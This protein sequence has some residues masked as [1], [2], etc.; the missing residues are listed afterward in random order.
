MRPSQNVRRSWPVLLSLAIL[1]SSACAPRSEYFGKVEPPPGQVFRFNNAAEPEYLDPG[2]MVGQ[3]EGR[4]A[5]L[6]FEGLT[7]IDSVTHLP[8]PGIAESWETSPDGK[9]Y[10]FH[11]RKDAVWS[12]GMPVTARDFVFAWTRVL[13]PKLASRYANLIYFI[14][15]GQEFN[16]GRLQD[17]SQLGLK[18]I[19]DHTLQV[20]LRKPVPF[21][22]TLTAFFSYLPV[23][24]H[25]VE[26][27]AE[28]WSNP[29]H[30]VGN[31][32]F[33]LAEHQ[34]NAKFEF[35]KN[36]RYWNA[37]EVRLER[38]IAYSIDDIHTSANMYEAGILDWVP[39]GSFPSSYVPYMRTRYHDLDSSV[40]LAS[41]YYEFNVTRRPL[42]N[43]LVRRA[44]SMAVDRRALTDDLL[45]GGQIPTAHFVPKGMP[46]YESP[47]GPEYNP[48]EARRL[49]AEAGY[50]NG[51]GFPSIDILFNTLDDHKRI[52]EA[53]QQMW[54]KNLN[55]SVKVRNEEWASYLKSRRNLQYDVVRAGWIGDYPDPSTFTDLL[56]SNNGNND[57]GWKNPAY[58]RLI[59]SAR[60][61]PDPFKR[62]EILRKSEAMALDEMPI[63]PL[64]TYASN[65][66]IKPYV[67]GIGG[68]PTDQHLLNKVWID[69]EWTKHRASAE[70]KRD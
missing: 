8:V 52:A 7:T 28:H 33:L 4:I 31:G 43:R 54:S 65:Q 19:D 39:S 70:E 11:L 26:Q 21:F 61:E 64:Y 67:R 34:T 6:V 63:L 55:I 51:Q 10:T 37:R 44:L 5:E 14:E 60:D 49:L 45:R 66:L 40:Y 12:D 20:K 47:P 62:M 32:P 48:A 22:L 18:A 17:A 24:Q 42:D 15:N 41:Y 13:D 23:P 36:P 53:I 69:H 16:E 56:E 27:Y 25:V 38:V 1:C 59:A 46:G 50:P 58:D 3:P 2:L 57:S 9:L 30:I 68:S 29:A 35:L